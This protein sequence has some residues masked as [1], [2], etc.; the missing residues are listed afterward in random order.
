VR[1]QI[2]HPTGNDIARTLSATEVL[3][4]LPQ[5]AI[6]VLVRA[7]RM[8]T[9]RKG[10]MLFVPGDAAA[11][12]AVQRGRVAILARP[13]AG[14]EIELFTR[15]RGELFGEASLWFDH[16]IN[17]AR[18]LHDGVVLRL[19]AA[20]ARAALDDSLAATLALASLMARRLALVE[21]RIGEVAV[22]S[23]KQRLLRVFAR[24]KAGARAADTRGY[25][26]PDRLTQ[27]ELASMV[28]A[29]RIAVSQA[30]RALRR[31]GHIR[32]SGRRI[33]VRR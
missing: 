6:A 26:L 31:T 16:Q 1:K 11:V 9:V 25:L 22:H 7:C 19:Q 20:A 30:L 18:A 5:T 8:I 17:E 27:E 4:V 28:G 12:Y 29:S 2:A 15:H 32:M 33:I 23:V 14:Q 3:Q 24:L 13:E 21:E 10:Q